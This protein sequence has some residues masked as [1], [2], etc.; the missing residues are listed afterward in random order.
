MFKKLAGEKPYRKWHLIAKYILWLGIALI[1]ACFIT[2]QVFGTESTICLTLGYIAIA[3]V[4]IFYVL[5]FLKW[6]CPDC[7]KTFPLFGPIIECR[8]C[9][10]KFMDNKGKQIW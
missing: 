7:N 10:R 3:C 8:Y 1:I 2:G 5:N 6:R 4:I 9:K